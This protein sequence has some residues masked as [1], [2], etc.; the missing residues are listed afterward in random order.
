M[1]DLNKYFLSNKKGFTLIEVVMIIVIL[2]IIMPGIMLY[3]I[4]GVKD[5][6]IPQKRTTAI[7]LAEAL[8]EEIKSKGWDEVTTIDAT[9][10]NATLPLAAEEA[11]RNLYDDVDDFNGVVGVS[12]PQNSQGAS[13]GTAYQ[14][15]SQ[16]VAVYYVN[17]GALDTDAGTR[18]CYK[19]IQVDITDTTSNEKTILVSLMTSY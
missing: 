7:F 12:P 14:G 5:S 3:F 6:A 2:G 8:M 16:T 4:T 13:L 10:S 15:F 1:D 18:T 9:C 17:P 19:R 11:T